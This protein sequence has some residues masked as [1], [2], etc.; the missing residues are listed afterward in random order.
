MLLDSVA[1]AIDI[2]A[3]AGGEDE[4]TQ[5]VGVYVLYLF[6]LSSILFLVIRLLFFIT[7]FLDIKHNQQMKL[8]N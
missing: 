5:F 8:F 7:F 6:V 1:V 2:E 3:V 4:T